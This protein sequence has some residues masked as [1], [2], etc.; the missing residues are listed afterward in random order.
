M[1]TLDSR[2]TSMVLIAGGVVSHFIFNKYEP[3][4]VCP[5]LA[6][7]LGPPL[8]V[9]CFL[10]PPDRPS[11]IEILGFYAV[12]LGSL[13]ASLV[14]Y[15][16]SPY[17]PLAAFPGPIICKLTRLWG[18]KVVQ[19]GNQH[20]YYKALHARYGP[21]VRTGPNHIHISD[22]D[23]LPTVMGLKPFR[24]SERGLLTIIDP[25][26]HAQRRKIWDRSMNTSAT[27]GYQDMLSRRIGQLIHQLQKR[28]GLEI[29]LSMWLSFLSFDFMGDLAFGGKFRLSEQG[30]DVDGYM[31]GTRQYLKFQESSGVIPWIKP[32][33][34]MLPGANVMKHFLELSKASVLARMSEGS[35]N[36]D[37]FYYLLDEE[38]I[39]HGPPSLPTLIM[40][41]GLAI[42]SGSDTTGTAL[43]N[44]FFYLLSNPENLA[45]LQKEVDDAFPPGADIVSPSAAAELKY[46]NAVIN[47]TLRLQPAVPSGATRTL[48]L[49]GGGVHI[50]GRWLPEGTTVQMSP[51]SVHRDPRYFYPD[52]ECYCPDRWLEANSEARLEQSAY[53]PFSY[54]P[55][56]CV[57]KGLAMLELRMVVCALIQKFEFKFAPSFKSR[58]WEDNL[59]DF[60]ILV[61]GELPVQMKARKQ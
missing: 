8:V 10:C 60:F 55:T 31:K 19:T 32:L 7:I 39:G 52:P 33:M 6:L 13:I 28:Q 56:G 12:H 20:R 35:S 46:L 51:Y 25:Q 24:R 14:A 21:Y 30:S 29:D 3:R 38:G 58:D 53:F 9:A 48:P 15:L 37:I 26:E 42:V 5:T 59:A 45:R 54:G 17:H 61:K 44:V 40:E 34:W 41:S 57:G 1:Q 23:A 27:L 47:E 50:S 36:K 49:G 2:L 4:R 22:A 18:L 11:V 16:L 43:S